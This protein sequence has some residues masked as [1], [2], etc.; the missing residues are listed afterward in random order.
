[1]VK[2]EKINESEKPLRAIIYARVSTEGQAEEEVPLTAQ[3]KEC[4]EYVSSH[5]WELV[6][7]V[8][9]G[10]ISGRTDERPGF[11]RMIAMAKEKPKPFDVIVAWKAN[12][13]SRKLEHRL[14]YQALLRRQGIRVVLVKEP[15]FDGALGFLVESV[16]AVVDEF[17]TLQIGEDTLRGQKEIARQGYSAGGRPPKGYR[18]VRKVVGLKKGSEPITRTAWEP[19]PEWQHQA[20]EAFQMAANGRSFTEIVRLTEVVTNKSSLFTYLHN[21]AFIGDR[22]YNKQ[23]HVDT[24]AIRV[25]NP[26]EDWVVVPNAHEAIVPVELFN[27]VQEILSQK[28]RSNFDERTLKSDYLLSGLLW[29]PKHDCHYVG[30]AN[31]DREYYACSLRNKNLIPASECRLLKKDAIEKFIL[32]I[33]TDQILQPENVRLGLAAIEEESQKE[34]EVATGKSSS[35]Q[36]QIGE[37]EKELTR[38]QAAVAQGVD[39]GALA[40]PMNRCYQRLATL[41]STLEELQVERRAPTNITSRLVDEVIQSAKRYLDEGKPSDIKPLLRDLV[42][43]IEVSGEEVTLLYTFRKPDTEVAYVLAPQA[44]FEPAT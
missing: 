16:L 25:N 12:R 21:R 39:P 6:E 7:V 26:Q 36:S 31:R 32:G 20:L 42:E 15:E 1:V 43:R 11:Q 41:R 34:R 22:V 28:K 24:K 44:G 18:S 17:L 27:Q 2:L 33:I 29:C 37:A 5:G 14:T 9:D 35:L 40:E 3:V 30:W 13:L 19:D 23:R 8:R 38:Y 10:G 4:E